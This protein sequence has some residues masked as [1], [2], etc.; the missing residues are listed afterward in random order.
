MPSQARQL[1]ETSTLGKGTELFKVAAR[2]CPALNNH[3]IAHV[4]I[5]DADAHFEMIRMDLAGTFM[6][7]CFGGRGR[8]LIDGRW[9]LVREGSAAVAPPH[10]VLAFHCEP[11]HR[12]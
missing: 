10:A 6:L 5:A 11:G 3:H 9:Q 2:D 12:W 7:A 4:A 1:V 8:V